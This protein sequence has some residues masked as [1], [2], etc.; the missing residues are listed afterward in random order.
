MPKPKL[1]LDVQD[2]VM[3]VGSDGS[4]MPLRLSGRLPQT[5]EELQRTQ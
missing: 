3:L 1:H 4:A 2:G 5:R